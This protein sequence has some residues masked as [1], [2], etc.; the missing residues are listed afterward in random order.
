[1]YS[2]R[3]VK[4]ATEPPQS[5]LRWG[6]VYP[7]TDW[8]IQHS[9]PKATVVVA[10]RVGDIITRNGQPHVYWSILGE[11][12]FIEDNKLT[13]SPGSLIENS[14]EEGRWQP[15]WSKTEQCLVF[16]E[17]DT[18]ASEARDHCH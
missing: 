10:Q 16:G 1:M 17:N 2:R 12:V 8:T 15:T 6:H 4:Q 13:W 11:S 18:L 14:N 3:P 5:L 9:Q 7:R